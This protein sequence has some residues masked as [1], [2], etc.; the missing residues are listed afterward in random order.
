MYTAQQARE[1]VNKYEVHVREETLENL[2]KKDNNKIALEIYE[3]EIEYLATKGCSTLLVNNTKPD[4]FDLVNTSDIRTILK[5]M[6]YKVETA[7]DNYV[8][9]SW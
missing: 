6:G 3:A 1:D 5:F 2:L 9:I 7:Y 4:L 8:K